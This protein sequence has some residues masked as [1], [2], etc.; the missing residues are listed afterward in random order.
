MFDTDTGALYAPKMRRYSD[1]EEKALISLAQQGNKLARTRVME[2]FYPLLVL[3][4]HQTYRALGLDMTIISRNELLGMGTIGLEKSIDKFSPAAGVKFSTYATW[5]I[6][7]SITH[8]SN[9]SAYVVKL[10][11]TISR[12]PKTDKR[13]KEKLAALQDDYGG[14]DG[15]TLQNMADEYS[16]D[17]L[18]TLL[19][20]EVC[21]VLAGV[22]ET[23]YSLTNTGQKDGVESFMS[24]HSG[25]N[26]RNSRFFRPSEQVRDNNRQKKNTVMN[27]FFKNK[28]NKATKMAME[29]LD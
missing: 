15:I 19:K 10:P 5:G 16:P 6:T 25:E 29:L 28:A 12:L 8:Q 18:D 4:V 27:N 1:A 23:I 17:P 26:L 11:T 24:L 13:K 2:T 9:Y 21:T 3:V 7:S 22:K 20:T 14:S